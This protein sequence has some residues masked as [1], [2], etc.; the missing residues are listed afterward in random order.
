MLLLTFFYL[1]TFQAAN[2]QGG[3]DR[4]EKERMKSILNNIKK[5]IKKN[6][7][8]SNF[9]GIDIEARFQKAED[10][11]DQVASVGQAFAV[12]AQAL[13]DFDDS[14][15]FFLPP[16]TNSDVEYGFK[17]K[18]IGDKTFVT[19]V[20]PK[21]DA[22]AKGLKTGDQI[23]MFEGFRPTKKDLWKMTYY[24]YVLSPKT[25]LRLNIL[26]PNAA[27][28]QEI[29]VDSKIIQSKR[30]TDINNS[31][32]LNDLI[33]QSDD[34]STRKI[35]YFQ[36]VGNTIIWKMMTFSF[37]PK[38]V[39]EMM[40]EVRNSTNLVLDLRGNGGGYI[41][42]LEQ[43]TGNFFD[44]DIKIADLKG[45][46]ENKKEGELMMAKSA[47][48]KSYNGKLV[49]LVDSESGS[50]AE[51]FARLVQLE[52]RGIVLGDISAGAVMQAQRF[53]GKIGSDRLVFYGTSITNADVIMSDGKS[54]EHIGVVPDEI[55]IPTA[56]DLAK[57]SDPALRRAIEILG[58]SVSAEQA[59]KLFPAEKW[60][61]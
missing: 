43:L 22:E 49:V 54:L 1:A 26:H 32:D 60:D 36:R 8:D 25:K 17:M 28:P 53:S 2:A 15:L 57:E 38:R 18:L 13:I 6:Y 21:S 47:G 55:I 30:V 24:Y 58:G 40:N 45:R 42:T 7:Y 4:I 23:L 56:E 10:R 5:D 48:G 61:N 29:S 44:K 50:A 11:L 9:H 27:E 46:E 19:A 35:S 39:D 31:N 34:S 41:K 37:D 12:I 20:K 16:A 52:K 59:G 51:I 33:R 14:H 3:Y